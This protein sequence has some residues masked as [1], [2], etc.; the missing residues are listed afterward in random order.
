MNKK[1]ELNKFKDQINQYIQTDDTLF[2]RDNGEFIENWKQTIADLPDI[3][4]IPKLYTIYDFKNIILNNV[5]T[6]KKMFKENIVCFSREMLSVLQK[7]QVYSHTQHAVT[8]EGESGTGKALMARAM[9]NYRK[10]GEL[11]E[12]SCMAESEESL[13]EIIKDFMQMQVDGSPAGLL[14]RHVDT[15]SATAIS[16]IEPLLRLN[17]GTK[18]VYFTAQDNFMSDMLQYPVNI[19]NRISQFVI[20]ISPL[21]NRRYDLFFQIFYSLLMNIDEK[22]FNFVEITGSVVK[23]LKNYT[24]PGNSIELAYT[25]QKMLFDNTPGKID[26]FSVSEAIEN[27]YAIDLTP[28]EESERKVIVNYLQ[29]NQYNKAQTSRDLGITINTL[30][31]KV[32]KYK[33]VIPKEQA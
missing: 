7:I 30:N 12:V 19:I 11:T 33:V 32:D 4:D 21:R 18:Y 25:I 9:H 3:D 28:L 16:V 2:I 10:G 15:L 8:F 29:K 22:H 1:V 23:T 5:E 24:W 20:S 27:A 17:S 31:A 13:R 6:F 26:S 14:I